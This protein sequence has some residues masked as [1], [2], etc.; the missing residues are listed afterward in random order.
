LAYRDLSAFM[1]KLREQEGAGARALEFAI[2]TA[3]R[4]GEVIGARWSEINLAE[5]LWTIPAERMKAGKQHRVP[6]S[7][8]A[9]AILEQMAV[10][11]S[12]EFVFSGANPGRALSNMALL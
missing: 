9:M 6:L 4:T 7:G 10:M 11:R 2:L 8:S 12:G 3:T 1:A 5:R